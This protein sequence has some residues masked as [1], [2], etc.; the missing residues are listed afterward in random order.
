[1][2]DENEKNRIPMN[3]MIDKELYKKIEEKRVKKIGATIINFS[4]SDTVN[5]L[6]GLGLPIHDLREELGEAE[7]DRIWNFILKLDLKKVDITKII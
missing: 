5:H 1:M 3:V 4:R 7:F 6:V 2:V